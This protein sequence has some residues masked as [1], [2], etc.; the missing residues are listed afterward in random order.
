MNKTVLLI[1]LLGVLLSPFAYAHPGG[2]Y[3][4]GSHHCWTNCDSWGEEYGE[5]HYHGGYSAPRAVPKPAPVACTPYVLCPPEYKVTP[6]NRGYFY[7]GEVPYV[8]EVVFND[9]FGRVPEKDES[10]YWKYRVRT[11]KNTVNKL[12][13][14]MKYFR[15]KGWTY[16]KL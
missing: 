4:D 3:P 15:S 2:T 5:L 7:N 12:L 9:V 10:T 14:T 6:V 11:G 13:D 8:V 16:G 1:S